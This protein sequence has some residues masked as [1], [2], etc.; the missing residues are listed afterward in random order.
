MC[1]RH[2]GKARGSREPGA[3]GEPIAP[4]AAWGGDEDMIEANAEMAPVPPDDLALRVV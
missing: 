1:A 2:A 3:I 4:G